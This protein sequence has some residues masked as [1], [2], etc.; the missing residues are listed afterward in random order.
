MYNKN[1]KL[2][3]DI[4]NIE[5]FTLILNWIK[6]NS[7]INQENDIYKNLC[8]GIMENMD[9]VILN[10]CNYLYKDFSKM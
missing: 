9:W 1:N 5:S 2:K 8:L 3:F 10:N 6:I 7:N 4:N